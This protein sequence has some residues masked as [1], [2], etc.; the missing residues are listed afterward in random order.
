[1]TELHLVVWG[2]GVP[3]ILVHG[4]M[5]TGVETF[6]EQKPLVD[7]YR[8]ILLDRRG[9]GASP[10]TRCS[11]FEV[12]AQDIV[13]LLENPTHLVGHSYGAV[14]CLVAAAMQ[15]QKILSLTVIEP[16][17]FGLVRGQ[18]PVPTG[19]AQACSRIE[20][21]RALHRLLLR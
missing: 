8:L 14:A 20:H 7:R 18:E 11:D 17:A 2:E 10:F 4:S 1:M 12:D 21:R 6:S 5:S 9:Y 15:P 13:D 16:P 19:P 3:V